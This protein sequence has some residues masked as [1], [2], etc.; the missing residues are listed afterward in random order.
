MMR[1]DSNGSTDSFHSCSSADLTPTSLPSGEYEV[2]LSFRG[3]DVRKTFADHLYTSLVRSKFRTF[4]DEEELRK[5]GTIGPSIIRAIT[6]SKIY[7]PILTPNYASSKWC[8]QELAKMVE[9]WKSGGGAK[10]QHIILPVFLFVDPR[11]VRHTESGSYKEAFEQHSQKHDPETVLEWKEAL[12]EVGRMKGYHVTESDGH[13]SIIDKILTEVELHLRANYKLVTDELVGIDSPVDEVVGLL[14]LDSSAS[15]KIIGIH[16]MGGLGKTTLAKAVYDKVFTRFERC[17]FLEN[18]R[19]TLSEK[20]GVLIMQNKIISG[21]LRKDFNEAKYASDG[22][23]II[24]DRVCRHKLLIVL[25][26]VDEKFQF[27]EVLG[28]LDN[29]SMDSRFLITTRDARGL[30]LLRECKMFELQEMSPDH[31]LTLFNKNAFGVDCPPEDYAILSKEFVQAAA[32]LPLYI[33]V[34]GSLL[35]CMDKI[36]WEEK[37]EELKKISPTKV[38]ERLKISYNELT[39]NEK[40]I[41][42]DIA[43]YFI[44]L[45]KIEP[46]LMWS[47]CDFYPESTIRYLTQRSLIKLQRSEVKGDDINTFQMHNHVRDLGRAI[48]R[49]ENNQN[50]YKRSR[51]WSNKDAIDMLKHKKGTDCVE[52]LTVDMEGEDLIL[53]NKELEKLTRLRYLSV[54]NARLAGD[55]KDVLPNL[56]WLRLHSCDSVPTGLYLNKLVDLELV[57]CSVR[58]GW[59]GWN[60]LKVARKLKAVS[61]KRCFHLKKV[62]DFSDCEDLEWLAFSECRKMRGEVDIGNFKSLRYLLISNTKITKIKGEIGRLRN[63]KYLHADHSSLKEVPAGISKLSSLEW[64]SLTLTD[65]YKSDFTEMLPASLTVLSI[66]NDMQKSSPDISVDNLQRLPNLS[67]LIN[68]SMLILDVG[69]GEILGLGELKMLEYLVIERAPRVVHLDGLE[70]LV[71]LKTISVKGCPVLGKLPSLVAL[72]RLEVLW[73][74]DCP[75]ITEVHGVGQ[76]WESLSNLNVVGCSALIGLEALHSMVKLRS[77]ILMGAKITETVPSS[78][79]MFTQLTTL[80]LC[81]MSQEQFPNLSNL[82]N[83][84]ELGMDY[85]LELIEVPG[86]DTLESLEYLSLSGCQS[87]RKVPDLSGMKKLKTLDVE[88]CIQLKEVEGLERLESLEELKMSGCKSIEELPN[89]SG[90]KNLRELLLK[91]C[92]Q[93]KEVNGLEGLELTVFEARKRIKGKYVMKSFARHG[94]QLLTSRSKFS[95]LFHSFTSLH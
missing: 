68:L 18:I 54:S 35:F 25:D 83:L 67:N 26:D 63:L 48:V 14:N 57:D 42:L 3:P 56:R 94:K 34:I 2:F 31:S 8:L 80:G 86:L 9:C 88:G 17:F 78:L 76:L 38:Q 24:R 49:E 45:S 60:E 29:F 93:L 90:L 41:F 62:P 46:I 74:V 73:I 59:K 21:I 13:G 23:R 79:S 70:N 44:G 89:L 55:F 71:L 52:V 20:N 81:F 33:K 28:K 85:C 37:L 50:P 72:T 95:G 6:E 69:I 61:L 1:S 75:L 53:T 66:S 58:D 40:Q 4:R 16:G 27:D 77:L 15:E 87:I 82:K 84:R 92:I 64:L 39:H 5:G 65:P 10:G 32:G 91:G 30:E 43:C 12:Q 19:D 36:F 22:I 11:D 7:I 51:I 47:D